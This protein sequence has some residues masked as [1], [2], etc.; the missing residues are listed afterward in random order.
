MKYKNLFA[1]L[2][3]ILILINNFLYWKTLLKSTIPNIS[4]YKDYPLLPR[5][6]RCVISSSSLLLLHPIHRVHVPPWPAT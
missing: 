1:F 4:S 3:I 6:L 5:S 2:D